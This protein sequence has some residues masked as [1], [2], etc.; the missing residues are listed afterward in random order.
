MTKKR[1]LIAIVAMAVLSLFVF[2][3]VTRANTSKVTNASPETTAIPSPTALPDI[4]DA[5]SEKNGEEPSSA[6]EATP[7]SEAT[8][9]PEESVECNTVEAEYDDSA[10][11]EEDITVATAA[12]VTIDANGHAIIGTKDGKTIDGGFVGNTIPT[13]LH[14]VTFVNSDNTVLKMEFVEHGGDA[15]PPENVG[16]KGYEFY[17]WIGNYQNVTSNT[18]V[19]ASYLPIGLYHTVTYYDYDGQ[20]LRVERVASGSKAI[21][22][23]E[24][25]EREGYIFVGWDQSYDVVEHDLS[26]TAQYISM[27]APMFLV[28]W[29]SVDA[30]TTEATIQIRLKNNP[31]ICSAK[32]LIQYDEELTLTSYQI[33]ESELG[34]AYVGPEFIPAKDSAVFLWYKYDG[35]MAEDIV[36]ATLTFDLSA[37]ITGKHEIAVKYD[38]DDLFN[39]EEENV[40]FGVIN[41]GIIVE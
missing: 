40:F 11:Q 9:V 20:A 15:T 36:F 21:G 17:K 10:V 22:P 12:S 2:I 7:F 24:T 32:L 19:T 8:P 14:A 34:G 41:G 38:Q 4:V 39:F 26:L 3:V 37:N 31:G 23:S 5:G 1:I 25:P 27:D 16:L 6:P 29:V 28:D 18:V 33:N 30:G 35:D 13:E